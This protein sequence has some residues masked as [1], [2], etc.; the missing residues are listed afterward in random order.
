MDPNFEAINK[1]LREERRRRRRNKRARGRDS[2][3]KEVDQDLE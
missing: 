3:Y 1:K 2:T